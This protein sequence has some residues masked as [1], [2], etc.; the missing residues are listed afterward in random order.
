[1]EEHEER[2]F[3]SVRVRPLNEKERNNVSDWECINDTT[4]IYNNISLSPSE[5][6]MYPSAYTF[7]HFS[8]F[9]RIQKLVTYGNC[10]KCRDKVYEEAAK[11]VALSVVKG[12]NCE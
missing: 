3:A 11:D 8:V 9:D 1:M 4:I 5:R 6:L 10:T 7:D 12:F 2:I